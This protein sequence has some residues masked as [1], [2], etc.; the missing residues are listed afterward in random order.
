M[1]PNNKA[2]SVQKWRAFSWLRPA[3]P[4]WVLYWQ[5][6]QLNDLIT[7][8]FC[9]TLVAASLPPHRRPFPKPDFVFFR[10]PF[11]L[12]FSYIYFNIFAIL[13]LVFFV[14]FFPV[15]LVKNGANTVFLCERER[16]KKKKR[17]SI[18]HSSIHLLITRTPAN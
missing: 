6:P 1:T 9:F 12:V 14:L 15:F 11:L 2:R 3:L 16:E 17:E 5:S 13:L 4:L 7:N 18:V 10:S 8:A